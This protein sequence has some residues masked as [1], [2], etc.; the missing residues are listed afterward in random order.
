VV[1]T[2]VERIGG[3]VELH[4]EPGAGTSC[5]LWVPMLADRRPA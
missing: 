5:R 2:N 4:S 1:K 3:S